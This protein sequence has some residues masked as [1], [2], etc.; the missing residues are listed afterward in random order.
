[1]ATARA[2]PAASEPSRARRSIA[3]RRSEEHTSELQSRRELVC[4]LPLEK[5]KATASP[6]QS[7]SGHRR[8]EG[9]FRPTVGVTPWTPIASPHL[10]LLAAT[11]AADALTAAP[12]MA[13]PQ[14]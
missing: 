8:P 6:A 4:R 13:Q 2:R 3:Q 7:L 5:K 14:V 11:S 10:E 1:M 12:R 9:L